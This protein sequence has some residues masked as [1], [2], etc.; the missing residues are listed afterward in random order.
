M[1][2]LFVSLL[3]VVL[4]NVVLGDKCV[5]FYVDPSCN[6][7]CETGQNCGPLFHM[8]G[9]FCCHVKTGAPKEPKEA[10]QEMSFFVVDPETGEPKEV[11]KE[12]VEAAVP[13]EE[14]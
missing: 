3:L 11:E 8:E 4:L 6:G 10:P 1:K 14:L 9:Y 7:E 13:K 5:G 12:K 2:F